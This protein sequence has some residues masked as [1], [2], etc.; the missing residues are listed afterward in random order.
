MTEVEQAPAVQFRV[1]HRARV[2]PSAQESPL[3]PPLGAADAQRLS[4]NMRCVSLRRPS[5]ASRHCARAGDDGFKP[6]FNGKDLTG[7]V[8]VNCAPSTFFVK[9]GMIVTTGKPTGFLRTDKQ[10]EN[11]ILEFDWMHVQPKKDASATPACS[12][13]AIRSRPSARGFTRGIEVQVLVNL[14]ARTGGLHQPRRHLQHLG[15][16]VQAR[17]AA[18]AAAGSA[19]CPARTAAR[20]ADEWN[21]YSVDAATTASSS[22]RSTARKS[23]ASASAIR[24]RA[25]WPSKS[26]GSECHFRNIKIKELPSTNPKPEEIA[27]EAKGFVNA[28]H[29]PGPGRLEGRMATRAT[30]SRGTGVLDYDGK[31]GKDKDLW[32]EK[33]YGDFELVCRLAAAGQAEED[34]AARDPAQRRIRQG[35]RRQAEGGRGRWTPATAASTCAARQEPDQHLVL[36]DRLRRGLRLPHRHEDAAEVRTGVT[37]KVK[38]DKPLGQWNRFIITHEGRPP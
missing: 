30:G 33:E 29:R 11:F 35:R 28:V 36:A 14:E 2:A 16:Q 9:D 22:W 8:N 27:D 1:E 19:A 6:L 21:H 26:E 24:A 37:P 34:E 12:S 23:P 3:R 25:T 5:C 38:A 7:W 20:A 18:P 10:Y 31:S 17:P 15:R 32:T 4:M 13:G